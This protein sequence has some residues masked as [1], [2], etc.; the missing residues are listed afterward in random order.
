MAIYLAD[1]GKAKGCSATGY[2]HNQV[3]VK[4][5]QKTLENASLRKEWHTKF[6]LQELLEGL[7]LI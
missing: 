4:R 5:A 7:G 2:G 3:I 6:S 1:P